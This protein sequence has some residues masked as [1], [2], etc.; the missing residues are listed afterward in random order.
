MLKR[1]VLYF[2]IGCIASILPARAAF[3]CGSGIS[4]A[5]QALLL[6]FSVVAVILGV[7][8][9]GVW[10]V[11]K[12]VEKKCISMQRVWYVSAG[13]LGVFLM[14]LV[15]FIIPAVEDSFIHAGIEMPVIM[16]VLSNG[17]IFLLGFICVGWGCLVFCFFSKWMRQ[18]VVW[19][20][21]YFAVLFCVVIWGWFL[22][23]FF[24][25]LG[26]PF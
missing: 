15:Y 14:W 16:D 19:I 3:A 23:I 5:T 8:W 11:R 12:C 24:L 20:F 21:G 2:C 10:L 1:F 7:S 26:S 9:L 4:F 25:D 22:S 17:R 18:Y 13:L 6:Q